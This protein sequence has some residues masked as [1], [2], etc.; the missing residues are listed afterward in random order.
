[1]P[2][3]QFL[4]TALTERCITISCEVCHKKLISISRLLK[5][6]KD[7]LYNEC[8]TGMESMLNLCYGHLHSSVF[9]DA[10]LSGRKRCGL[11]AEKRLKLIVTYVISNLNYNP[12][13]MTDTD[14]PWKC[15]A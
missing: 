2:H 14:L 8:H 1:M 9:C 12:E 5:L 11:L 15:V 7:L 6:A 10:Y 4:T 3:K 13:S